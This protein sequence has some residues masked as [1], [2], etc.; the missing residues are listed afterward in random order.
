MPAASQAQE[1]RAVSAAGRLE[2]R[3]GLQTLIPVFRRNQW[4][5]LLIAGD[6]GMASELA[7]PADGAGNIEF[8]GQASAERL[9]TLY[10]AAV[11]V[12]SLRIILSGNG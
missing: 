8:L 3:K 7:R 5:R 1:T 10:R 4:A 9:V 6:G 2:K 12:I 11:A